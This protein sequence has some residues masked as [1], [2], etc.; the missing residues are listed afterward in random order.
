MEWMR[1]ILF[2]R[3]INSYCTTEKRLHY[4]HLN[5]SPN[6]WVGQ[7]CPHR[8]H[9]T[10][11]YIY[12]SLHISSNCIDQRAERIKTDRMSFTID[13][14]VNVESGSKDGNME[15]AHHHILCPS[16]TPCSIAGFAVLPRY[17][18]TPFLVI[19]GVETY[20]MS[21]VS[22]FL[23]KCNKKRRWKRVQIIVQNTLDISTR[24]LCSS[25]YECSLVA[26]RGNYRGPQLNTNIQ[27]HFSQWQRG[28]QLWNDK[29][30]WRRN[31]DS[32]GSI[33]EK[34]WEGEGLNKC[35]IAD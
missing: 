18:Q 8:L 27:S 2:P 17:P 6:S 28:W 16:N 14:C 35:Y 29:G 25:A 21:H 22:C 13:I 33:K 26:E 15:S 19:G 5:H 20:L 7:K 1:L 9:M 4:T 31:I 24:H 32:C 11:K 12:M 30:S 34:A 10:R 23:C 3:L